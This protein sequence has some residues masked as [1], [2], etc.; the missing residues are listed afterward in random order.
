MTYRRCHVF[1][2][3]AL[4]IG[5]AGL[6]MFLNSQSEDQAIATIIRSGGRVYY[7]FQ[8]PTLTTRS[9]AAAANTNTLAFGTQQDSVLDL[10]VTPRL[11]PNVAVGFTAITIE[12]FKSP[13]VLNAGEAI[14]AVQADTAQLYPVDQELYFEVPPRSDSEHIAERILLDIRR[15]I[16]CATVGPRLEPEVIN[17]LTELRQLRQLIVL[18]SNR[19][20][21]QELAK[22]LPAV[23]IIYR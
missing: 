3:I 23:E 17:A 10:D 11:F 19:E 21:R 4:L 22:K 8:S 14:F 5:A 16:E 9:T 12:E 20:K 6:G 2:V 15:R 1:W 13:F 18:G 7:D